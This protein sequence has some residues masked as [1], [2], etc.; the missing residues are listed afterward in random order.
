MSIVTG[1]GAVELH[2]AVHEA[3]VLL[4]ELD[5]RLAHEHAR[6]LDEA[7]AAGQ[8]AVVPPVGVQ[9]RQRVGAARVVDLDDDRVVARAHQPGHLERERREAALVLAEAL[10]VQPH[11]RALRRRSELH[12]RAAAR[13]KG[14]VEAALIPDRPFVI[15][16]V[17]ALRVPVAGHLQRRRACEVVLDEVRLV[18]RLGV[19]E[20]AV[21]ARLAAVVEAAVVVRVDDDV[22]GAVEALPGAPVGE[23][24]RRRGR[25][26][27]RRATHAPEGDQRPDPAHKG[28]TIFS[29][30]FFFV[31][32]SCTRRSTSANP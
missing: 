1:V 13:L 8:A 18:A 16:Q 17:G 9:R 20:V 12:E 28:R 21:R 4:V 10:A 27:A 30:R 7:H 31:S 2:E 22:P 23:P 29:T 11:R 5:A 19:V 3:G 24:Q 14:G 25:C 6:R 32:R 15:E 26:S